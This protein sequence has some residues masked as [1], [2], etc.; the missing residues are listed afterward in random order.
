M[1]ASA[2]LFIDRDGTLVQ[3]PPDE[4]VD[5][6]EKIRL[7]RNVIPALIILRDA[8]FRFVMVSNQ[9]GLGTDSFSAESFTGP[10]EFIVN[11]FA[12]QGV[13]FDD[14][15]ICPHVPSDHCE[16]RK[17]KTGLV[18]TYL[19]SGSIDYKNSFVIG[20]RDCD[21]ELAR[22]MGIGGKRLDDKLG[23]L[24]IASQLTQ[25]TRSAEVHRE[26]RET[27]IVV[28]VDLDTVPDLQQIDT[29]IGFFDHMLEQVGRH[30]AFSLM[31]QCRGDLHI[32][33]HH[34]V[35]DSALAL[36]AAL[37]EALGDKRGIGRYGFV[38]P[39]DEACA[40]VSID[41]SGRPY[42]VF[43]GELTRESVGGLPTEL[44]PH[45]FRSVAEGLGAAIHISLRGENNH[46]M[47]EAA[48]KGLGRCL[49]QAIRREG[50]DLPSTKGV[51]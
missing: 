38:L 30:G 26:T 16:C 47:I 42:F 31:L 2:T 19:A 4:Q 17:P 11:L 5:S 28:K 24:D 1:K 18:Q 7:V 40:Q 22:R 15:L 49:R 34:T 25:P 27:N 3:E 6:L 23:W 41:L 44:V 46:H 14:I 21:M 45:F 35:E 9:D 50:H 36:G 37:R 33:E 20:D 43:D 13:V 10:Q 12:S 39:M 8:G 51:L 32:D 29:G 48:F